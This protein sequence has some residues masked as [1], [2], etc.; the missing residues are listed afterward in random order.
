MTIEESKDHVYDIVAKY[1]SRATVIWAEE[2]MVQVQH[3]VVT[4]KLRNLK[5]GNMS[6]EGNVDG[7]HTAIYNVSYSLEVNLY[8]GGKQVD[9]D[10]ESVAAMINTAISDLTQFVVYTHSPFVQNKLN[11]IDMCI[12]LNGQV[13]DVSSALKDG[14][15]EYR[16]MCE[17]DISFCTQFLGAYN[18]IEK[19]AS[20]GGDDETIN[21]K[22]GWFEDADIEEE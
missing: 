1:F 15:Y 20:G 5:I 17:F 2:Y 6:I 4:L 3:P 10:D 13:Q 22:T 11:H 7:E 9:G 8:T 14:R 12:L 16:A 19:T 21:A 18:T